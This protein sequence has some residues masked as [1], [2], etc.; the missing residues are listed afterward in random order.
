MTDEA[1]FIIKPDEIQSMYPALDAGIGDDEQVVKMEEAR[2]SHITAPVSAILMQGL[3]TQI[4]SWISGLNISRKQAMELLRMNRDE[5]GRESEIVRGIKDNFMTP[6]VA[7][8]VEGQL[9]GRI[10][11]PTSEPYI[12]PMNAASD[13]FKLMIDIPKKSDWSAP[14]P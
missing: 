2:M 10:V 14:K 11:V 5:H 6:K 4:K 7:G 3:N 1:Q 8:I 13:D 12:G 9:Q